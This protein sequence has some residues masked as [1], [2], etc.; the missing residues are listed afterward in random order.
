M[1]IALTKVEGAFESYEDILNKNAIRYA[2][3][4]LEPRAH[5]VCLDSTFR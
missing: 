1:F 2:N 3:H 5:E 4:P